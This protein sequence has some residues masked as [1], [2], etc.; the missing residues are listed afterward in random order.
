VSLPAA[1]TYLQVTTVSYVAVAIPA[2]VQ[3]VT[4]DATTLLTVPTGS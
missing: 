4:H 2:G 1:P 3:V